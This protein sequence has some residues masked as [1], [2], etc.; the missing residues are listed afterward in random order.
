MRWWPSASEERLDAL[1]PGA[2]GWRKH[3]VVLTVVFFV[4]TVVAVA[5]VEFLAQQLHLAEGWWTAVIAIAIAEWLIHRRRFFGTGI[6][7]ALWI[8]ALFAIIFSLPHSGKPE[9]ASALRARCSDA[10]RLR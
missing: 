1:R 8:G 5:A 6:E 3:G 10:R 9:A 4:L 7:S 2:S